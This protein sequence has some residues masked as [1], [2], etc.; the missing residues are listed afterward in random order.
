MSSDGVKYYAPFAARVE[1]RGEEIPF[2]FHARFIGQDRLSSKTWLT[3]SHLDRN[4]WSS[5]GFH[6]I[7]WANFDISPGGPERRMALG[8]RGSAFLRI[9]V[10]AK[11]EF[12]LASFTGAITFA[13]VPF[14]VS[15]RPELVISSL[16]LE[17]VAV[18]LSEPFRRHE[19][20]R[21]D[22]LY[23]AILEAGF[24]MDGSLALAH[25]EYMDKLGIIR[26]A[27]DRIFPA[28]LAGE[29]QDIFGIALPTLVRKPK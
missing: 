20:W 25:I 8:L 5:S 24:G 6:T 18:L 19:P 29:F 1:R 16:F 2:L 15:G 26:R 4:D 7:T 11:L 22:S 13:P 12:E 14:N 28:M 27:E 21:F 9:P 17:T 23:H 10:F 3:V